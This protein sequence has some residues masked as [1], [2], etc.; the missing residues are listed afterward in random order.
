MSDENLDGFEKLLMALGFSS[1][2]VILLIAFYMVV[3]K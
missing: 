2:I 3:I 1:V